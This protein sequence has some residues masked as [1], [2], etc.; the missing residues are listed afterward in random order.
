MT[1]KS[2]KNFVTLQQRGLS[3]SLV[4]ALMGKTAFVRMMVGNNM[5]EFSERQG[6]KSA[7]FSPVLE[8]SGLFLQPMFHCMTYASQDKQKLHIYCISLTKTD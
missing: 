1:Y 3:D 8:N 4:S 2:S 6:A 7:F 5:E